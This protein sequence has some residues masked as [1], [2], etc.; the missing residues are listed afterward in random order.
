[1]VRLVNAQRNGKTLIQAFH[2][3]PDMAALLSFAK[4]HLEKPPD[5][6]SN[7]LWTDDTKMEMF[8]H[9]AEHQI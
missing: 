4:L 8:G 6:W 7:V 2:F 3:R 9:N 5:F 1:M